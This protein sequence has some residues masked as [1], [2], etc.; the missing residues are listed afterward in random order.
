MNEIDKKDDVVFVGSKP[1]MVYLHSLNIA[2]GKVSEVKLIARGKNISRAVDAEEVAK[3]ISNTKVKSVIL[4][5]EPAKNKE[6]R[7]INVSTIEITLT[8]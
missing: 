6:G 2:F 1:T 3:R 5:S 8:K 4:G 7:D